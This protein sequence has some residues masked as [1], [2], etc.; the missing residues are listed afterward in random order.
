MSND[1]FK[2]MFFRFSK[3]ILFFIFISALILPIFIFGFPPK[4]FA[5]QKLGGEEG[6]LEKTCQGIID[7]GQQEFSKEKYQALLKEC[8]DFYEK[9]I[10]QME[11]DVSKTGAKKKTL[12]NKIYTLNKKIR[13]LSYQ[14]YQSNLVI[15]DLKVKIKGTEGSIQKTSSTIEES[16]NKLSNILRAINEEDQKST[17][18]ILFSEDNL[19]GFFNNLVA[20]ERLSDKNKELLQDIK[21]LK[22]NLVRQKQSLDEEKT[23]LE[24]TVQIQTFQ[25]KENARVKREQEQYLSITN[26]EY[27]KKLKEKEEAEKKAAA[28]KAK[29]YQLVGVRKEVTYKEALGIA[30]YA[31]SQIGVRPALLLGILSQESAIGRNVGQCYLKNASTGA[32]VVA[33]NGRVVNR[34]MKPSRDV[35]PFLKIIKEIN[36]E[37]ALNLNP[38]KTLVSCPM[39]F[40]WGGAMGPAQFIPSTWV[41]YKDRIKE[42]IGISPDPWDIRGAALVASIYLKDGLNK[43]GSEGKA[44]QAYFCGYPKNS[45]WCRWYQKNVL[46]LAECHQ[47]FIDKGTMPLRCQ[48]AVGL[49]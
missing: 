45:Y 20:L 7:S 17:I 38:F 24:Q 26:Q 36:S 18:E 48:E 40:G 19:S 47:N 25:K 49:K 28:I 11:K 29:I 10:A 8:Q 44:V 23:G 30:K 1:K 32:G 22:T 27:Q 2:M 35:S 37:K 34:V 16:K 14:I 5:S 33:Y 31:A 6:S 3:I 13:K 21:T 46:Y 43:Y 12:E 39:K 4:I 15:K 41:L 42:K 9:Q